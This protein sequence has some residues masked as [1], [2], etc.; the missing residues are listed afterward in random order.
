M[1]ESNEESMIMKRG[2]GELRR[3]AWIG[4]TLVGILLFFATF[5]YAEMSVIG[6]GV[7]FRPGKLTPGG[8]LFMDIRFRVAGHGPAVPI[9]FSVVEAARTP[10]WS[11]PSIPTSTFEVNSY[12]LRFKHTIP[13]SIPSTGVCLNVY[14]HFTGTALRSALL[15]SNACYG[16]GMTAGTGQ[17]I[18]LNHD[19]SVKINSFSVDRTRDLD[20][21][22]GATYPGN[23]SFTIRN[24]GTAPFARLPYCWEFSLFLPTAT[25]PYPAG[26]FNSSGAPC[27]PIPG[28]GSVT[29]TKVLMIPDKTS[30]IKV[31]VRVPSDYRDIDESNNKDVR[32]VT[33]LIPSGI[34]PLRPGMRG[35]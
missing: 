22:E 27:D 28:G 8:T 3:N 18:T 24:I 26:W 12:T 13:A 33:V 17:R 32:G 4:I 23:I 21:G 6:E 2:K 34:E 5:S 35:K 25:G 31:E 15:I 29:V 14:A 30:L 16:S 7:S 20:P 1:V 9:A 10:D 19:L 11:H